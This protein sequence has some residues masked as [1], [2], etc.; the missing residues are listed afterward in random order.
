MRARTY[1]CA[2]RSHYL[3]ASGGI[4]AAQLTHAV[5]HTNIANTFEP[6]QPVYDTDLEGYTRHEHEQVILSM[7]EE[8][9]R[10]ALDDFQ[11]G[12]GESLQRDW[13]AQKQQILEEL[14]QHSAASSSA[15]GATLRRSVQNVPGADAAASDAALVQ[16]GRLVRY[17][18]VMARL[19]RARAEGE[20]TPLLHA[21]MEA[22]DSLQQDAPRKRALLDAW[23]ALKHLVRT[24]AAGPVPCREYAAV[25]MDRDAFA[26]APGAAL[27]ERW[28]RGARAYLEAQFA[29]YMEQVIAS[30]P[31]QAQR[32]GVPTVRATVAAYLRVH[33]RAADGAWPPLLA[34]PLDHTTQA[35][36]WAMTYFLV[37]IGQVGEALKVVQDNEDVL[38]RTDAS[39]LA[40]LKVWADAPDRQLPPHL[41][42]HWM[43]EYVT[44]FRGT[45][46]EDPYRYALYRLLGRFDVAKKFPAALVSST[47]N[48][49]WLQLCLVSESAD[50]SAPAPALQSYTLHDLATK[51]EKY[52]EAHFDPKGQRPL[53]YFQLLLLV[54]RFE[55][56]VA[57]LYSRAAY[58][59]DA[60]HF[61]VALTYY[62]L[63]RVPPAAERS[64]YELL[65]HARDAPA[66]DLAQLLKR[67]S[68][69]LAQ[70]SRRDALAYISVLTLNADVP[71]PIGAEQV[72]Q[73]HELV[74][75]LLLDAPPA[76]IVELLGDVSADGVTAPGLLEQQGALLHL[77][78]RRTLLHAIVE[79]VAA[80]CEKVRRIHD[81]ILL[82][83]YADERDT[84]LAVLHRELGAGL[85]D[86]A[87]LQDLRAPVDQGI[88]P[89]AAATS[90]VVLARAILAS[91]AQQGH[92]SAARNVCHTLL[93]LKR[94]ASLY[95]VGDYE[96]ALQTL[97]ALHILPLDAEARK[98]VVSIT[99]KAEEFK[100]YDENLTKNFSEI[101]LM[102]MNTL[103]KLH[104]ALKT[105]VTRAQSTLLFE[106]RSQARAL[107]MWAGMLRFRMSNET[108]S[109]LTRLDVYVCTPSDTRSTRAC[110][111]TAAS[112]IAAP[113]ACACRPTCRPPS[114]R[115][116]RASTT[117]PRALRSA[118]ARPPRRAHRATGCAGPR[119]RPRAAAARA[120]CQSRPASRRR[121]AT[122]A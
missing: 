58:Q 78:D 50:A 77:R 24:D 84:V 62:G 90:T 36:L 122:G 39:F 79:P 14:G 72:A 108:Y 25:Y 32:G 101:A 83:H 65:V 37:R 119:P 94:A 16:R 117:T 19:N 45:E 40:C 75:A 20:T 46:P 87:P 116:A 67:Y 114:P 102:A 85:M 120:Q 97:E 98:D 2:D 44:R 27:R 13:Q 26:R 63:L 11:R 56:A 9:R 49:L 76:G 68:R 61:A 74:Q 7:I 17:D 118:S 64:Q 47:E 59:A 57:F 86:A 29:E 105:S 66:L 95:A 42:D 91:Y 5:Q 28:V 38:E 55:A 121:R 15:G 43:G 52:G 70:S 21:F 31:V 18:N 71:A 93:E 8:G 92:T 107:M 110:R 99:R 33:L 34:R 3:L 82:Y 4:D 6:L 35:P 88:A 60:V 109:Q 113:V 23:T 54:G 10:D 100:N 80:Q 12:L 96:P 53:H 1:F 104:E 103:Y 41:R 89:L 48:W 81:A 51:L 69:A 22:V 112:T 106:Y 30:H 111:T 115:S 73:C